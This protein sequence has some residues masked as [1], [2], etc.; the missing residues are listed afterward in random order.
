MSYFK[1]WFKKKSTDIVLYYR[2]TAGCCRSHQAWLAALLGLQL[3]AWLEELKGLHDLERITDAKLTPRRSRW[4]CTLEG[5]WR[6]QGLRVWRRMRRQLCPPILAGPRAPEKMYQY[7]CVVFDRRGL[8]CP[9]VARASASSACVF[10]LAAAPPSE[11]DRW[12]CVSR[13]SFGR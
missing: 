11:I 5:A 6:R 9:R 4:S 12:A 10:L 1:E 13:G 2:S 7:V 3:K 8:A